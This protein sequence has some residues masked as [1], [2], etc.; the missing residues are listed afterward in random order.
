MA[1]SSHSL[2]KRR[3]MS[4]SETDKYPVIAG[5]RIA[6]YASPGKQL[7]MNEQRIIYHAWKK[8]GS[9]HNPL[10]Y[11]CRKPGN[12]LL[13]CGACCRSYH[14][15]CVPEL[16]ER[17]TEL[18][19]DAC[20]KRGWH[21]HPPLFEDEKLNQTRPKV[22]NEPVQRTTVKFEEFRPVR[23]T[24]KSAGSEKTSDKS[25]SDRPSPASEHGKPPSSGH[26]D[27][28]R[29]LQSLRERVTMLEKENEAMRLSSRPNNPKKR[30]FSD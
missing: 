15:T 17:K 6:S 26:G 4:A 30:G 25:D 7:T 13:D 5:Y 19:C 16:S 12:M 9:P 3:R 10:C 20:V 28:M 22:M 23:G 21:N 11:T 27:V 29:S 18:Y 14:Q 2:A 1:E 8:S 24:S